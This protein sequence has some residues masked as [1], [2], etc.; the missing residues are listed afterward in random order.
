MNATLDGQIEA[1]VSFPPGSYAGL[2]T[3]TFEI[4][5]EPPALGDYFRLLGQSFSLTALDDNGQAVTHFTTPF[6]ITIEYSDEAIAGQD[7]L[8]LTLGYWDDAAQRWIPIPTAVDADN[9]RLVAVV[10]H[11]TIFAVLED[12][13]PNVPQHR[14]YLP[15]IQS[16]RAAGA[17]DAVD[18]LSHRGND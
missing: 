1:L 13:T 18:I 5:A 17:S 12:T 14:I 10:D 6:T 7:E 11:L 4:L 3:L 16:V 8:L 2:F 15:T 9:N